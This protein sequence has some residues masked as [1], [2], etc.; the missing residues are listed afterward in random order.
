MSSERNE[1]IRIALEQIRQKHH[2]RLT[3]QDVVKEARQNKKSV[4]HGEFD[5]NI[6]NAAMAH[7]LDRANELIVKYVTIV[8]VHKAIK[9]T[10]PYYV[11]DPAA[12][13]REAGYVAV[14]SPDLDRAAAQQIVFN[15][16]D[17]CEHSIERARGI[18][19]V[20]DQKFAGLSD[21]LEDMLQQIVA[22]KKRM[23]A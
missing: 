7:W 8:T 10:T 9:V 6:Q 11:R 16:L 18:A 22:V 4:L 12:K 19:H 15:E 21:M 20:L 2:G 1:A 14:T 3:K 17:R 5:W 23:A 13:T